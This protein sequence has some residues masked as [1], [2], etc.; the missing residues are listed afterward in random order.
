MTA[1]RTRPLPR[2]VLFTGLVLFAAAV[3]MFHAWWTIARFDRARFTYDS[4]QYALAARELATTGRLATP[5]SYVGPLRES[6]RPPY[7]LLAGHP[8]VPILEA[9]VF[10][11]FGAEAWISIVPAL[12]CHL[13]A[14]VLAAMLVLESGGSIFLAAA[15]GV[16]LAG[17]PL[18]LAYATEGL[19]EMPFTAAWTAAML[20]LVRL[21]RSSGEAPRATTV[22]PPVA[23][24]ILLGIAHLARPVVVPTLPLWLAAAAWSA[25]P[26]KRLRNALLV[27]AGFVPFA[28][29]LVLYK[30]RA[31]GHP[32]SEVGNIM[33][34]VGLA[35]EFGEYD[36]ARLLHPPDA[37]AWI[38]AH[39]GALVAK[40]AQNV[41]LMVKQSLHLGG[42]A[43]GLGF[44]W[45]VAR[46][47][48]DG[49]GPIR[50][51][52]GGSLALLALF[53]ALT[54][55][56]PHYL[57][58]MLPTVVALS[59]ISL[60]GLLRA[61]RIPTLAAHGLLLA[62]LSWASWRPLLAE[63]S[64]AR[65]GARPAEFTEREVAGLGAILSRRLPEGTIVS[66][67]MAP[68]ISWYANRASVNL[69]Y[70]VQ[71]LAE[72]RDRHGVSAVVLTNEWLIQ[73]PGNEAWR[74]LF[75]SRTTVPGWT[76][77]DVVKSGRLSAR[78][79]LADRAAAERLSSPTPASPSR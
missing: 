29:A 56:R 6:A 36:V 46:P 47:V 64:R 51:V 25:P 2:G 16:T 18:M 54:L 53:C 60:A 21:R 76:T 1:A 8:L 35:P 4:A 28:S 9:P 49:R 73:R 34:L 19:S 57:F 39:P 7:P 58:P 71:D 65:A 15:A 78:V 37:I 50:L 48:R 5:Y 32:F 33:L 66:S 40:L 69:P 70:A 27:G 26:G 59:T 41:P 67:D 72:L 24:G 10:A 22:L 52:A 31:A 38:R 63:W 74:D 13:L 11:V 30:W 20:F 3:W 62:M 45:S 79:L 68:W 43:V 61:T 42:W 17:S 23:L 12:L 14:V 55:A 77:T 75:L 44:L